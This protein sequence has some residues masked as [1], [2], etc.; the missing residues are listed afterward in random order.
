VTPARVSVLLKGRAELLEKIAEADIRVFIDGSSL[1]NPGT[2]E[3]PVTVH[4]PSGM[5]MDAEATPKTVKVTVAD[6][7]R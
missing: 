2:Y 1:E 5:D 3:L 7:Q 4:Y 6:R